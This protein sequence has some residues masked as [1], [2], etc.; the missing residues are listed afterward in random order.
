MIR[1]R[2]L[3]VASAFNKTGA[4]V[5]YFLFCSTVTTL[6]FTLIIFIFVG[7]PLLL[8]LSLLKISYLTMG[9]DTVAF[10]W[11]SLFKDLER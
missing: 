1:L 2:P 5:I 10:P 11:E 7:V 3:L 9:G 4:S 6:P 8:L